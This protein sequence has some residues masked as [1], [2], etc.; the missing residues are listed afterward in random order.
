MCSSK[1]NNSDD[2]DDDDD[3]DDDDDENDNTA[4]SHGPSIKEHHKVLYLNSN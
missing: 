4:N 1:F 2:V 3:G